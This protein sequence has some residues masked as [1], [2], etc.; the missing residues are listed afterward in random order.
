M[1][2]RCVRKIPAHHLLNST[3]RKRFAIHLRSKE[4]SFLAQKPIKE[5]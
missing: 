1:L 2:S 4:R 5:L 3:E